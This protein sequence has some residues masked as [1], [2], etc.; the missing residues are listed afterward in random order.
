MQQ[1]SSQLVVEDPGPGERLGRAAR[2]AL[3][4]ELQSAARAEAPAVLITVSGDAWHHAP[5]VA[6]YGAADLTQSEVSEEFQS[7]SARLF[8]HPAP[9]IV[10]LNGAVSGF[11]L[12]L[13]MAADVRVATPNA[14]F[15]LGS[16]QAAGAL[17]GGATWLLAR[18]VGTAL[19]ARMAWT[20]VVL[21]ADDAQRH[22]LVTVLSKDP[23][24]ARRLAQS[25]SD[26]PYATSALKRA[27]TS[28]Q[29]SD[30]EQ[31]LSY[32]SWLPAIALVK[33]PAE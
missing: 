32:E 5:E 22:G 30:L 13:A 24:H 14:T 16:T 9:V 15:G 7:L 29:A 21:D 6:R 23:S 3:R 33:G 26:A 20:G 11:G 2:A 19:L 25:L 17:L 18:A 1:S 31:S 27:L 4:R 28:R 12:A 10:E 8:C